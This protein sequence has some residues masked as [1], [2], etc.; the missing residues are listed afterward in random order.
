M[1]AQDYSQITIGGPCKITDGSAVFYTEGPAVLTPQMNWRDR[2]AS[3][4]PKQDATLVD[5]TWKLTFTPMSVYNSTLRGVLVPTTY[6]NWTVSGQRIIGAANRTV[7]ILGA[8][9]EEYAL[10][11]AKIT[12]LPEMYLGLG[13]SLWGACEYTA[14]L[15]QGNALTDANAFLTQS[16][17]GVWSQTDFPTTHQEAEC[18]LALSPLGGGSPLTGWDTVFAEEGFTLS[19]ELTLEP[20]KQGNITIDH[21]VIGYRG[22]L[23]FKPQ[24]PSSAELLSAL[25]PVIGTR[26]SSNANNVVVTGPGISV[27]L[28]SAALYTGVFNFDNKL[29][30]HGEWG[31]ISS[32]GVPG[33]RLTLA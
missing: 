16:T 21:K 11:R 28:A 20:L 9:G 6:T 30:R 19:H 25:N 15:G 22:M 12:K 31:L 27:T 33:T 18:T 32:P 1:P 24:E 23:K 7:T 26:R 14:Y 5:L 17:T 8:D 10:T 3:L 13:K 4:D 2:P 29:N